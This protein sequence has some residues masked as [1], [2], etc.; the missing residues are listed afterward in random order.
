MKHIIKHRVAL[1]FIVAVFILS[2]AACTILQNNDG[3]IKVIP[4]DNTQTT[5]TPEPGSTAKPQDTKDKL[6]EELDDKLESLQ[7]GTQEYI[8]SIIGDRATEVVKALR[9]KDL[10]KLSQAVHPEKG[11]RFSP[12]G[13]VNVETDLVFTREQVRN[14]G[15]DSKVYN[16][17]SYD[18][19]GLPIEL[20]F[21]G[22]YNKFIYDVDF[23]NAPEV[24]YN[25]V[26][27]KGNSLVNTLDVYPKAIVVEYHFPGFDPQYEGMDWRSLRLVFEKK[28]NTWY[29]VGIIHDQWTI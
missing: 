8:A 27:G 2:A 3:G 22:Y 25:K 9:E 20:D 10:E 23:M 28:D 26:L 24:A 16:W 29:I 5:T 6:D 13:Y 11:V 18:G 12:Y 1:I 17:G 19:S 7:N 21:E 14:L 4:K 15:N